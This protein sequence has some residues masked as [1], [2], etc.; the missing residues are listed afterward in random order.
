MG[1]SMKKNKNYK[2]LAIGLLAFTV[3][4]AATPAHAQYSLLY[5]FG[6]SSVADASGPLG[7]IAQGEDGS[8]VLHR[9]VRRS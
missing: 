2:M 1:K 8:F 9:V 6:V 3:L 7:A 4:S 5:N